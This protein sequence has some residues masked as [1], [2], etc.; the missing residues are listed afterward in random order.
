[1]HFGAE[2]E[3]ILVNFVLARAVSYV[4]YAM[5]RLRHLIVLPTWRDLG[6]GECLYPPGPG[7]TFHA[8]K[9][10]HSDASAHD[11]A[12]TIGSSILPPDCARPLLTRSLLPRNRV[13]I[14]HLNLIVIRPH[15][16][17]FDLPS[18][19]LPPSSFNHCLPR[20]AHLTTLRPHA[21]GDNSP[22]PPHL[23]PGN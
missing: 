9:H 6:F 22:N 12:R 10:L 13:P 4:R 18:N 7:R 23:P 3:I 14:T 2:I 20:S 5:L 1:M 16:N 8:A 19:A 21:L 15:P 11:Q 17:H